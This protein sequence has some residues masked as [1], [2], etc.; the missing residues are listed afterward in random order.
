MGINIFMSATMRRTLEAG[1]GELAA[2]SERRE[3]TR[4]AGDFERIF[5]RLHAV[6]RVRALTLSL[7]GR[8]IARAATD[9]DR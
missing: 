9:R 5:E 3:R 7:L 1:H 4:L 2:P 8:A 6:G